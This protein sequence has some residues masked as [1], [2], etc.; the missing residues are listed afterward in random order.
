M[1]CVKVIASIVNKYLNNK[2][3][4]YYILLKINI[5]VFKKQNN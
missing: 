1:I 3:F 2:K 4:K 5:C